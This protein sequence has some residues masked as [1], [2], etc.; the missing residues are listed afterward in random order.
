MG[1]FMNLLQDQGIKMFRRFNNP[2]HKITLK[3]GFPFKNK[4][5]G[6]KK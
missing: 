3:K 5:S 4:F 1:F 6:D 2:Y